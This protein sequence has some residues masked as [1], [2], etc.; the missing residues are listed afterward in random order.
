MVI[1]MV[2]MVFALM[3]IHAVNLEDKLSPENA[4]MI[5]MMLNVVII[6]LV[7]LMMEEREIVYLVVN[8]MGTKLVENVQEVMISFVVLVPQMLI[9]PIMDHALEEV[10]LALMLIILIVTLKLLLVNAQVQ[11]TLDVVLQEKDIYGTLTKMNTQMFFSK[12]PARVQ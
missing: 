3:L 8:V 7:Q 4:Q 1:A 12:Y 6:F 10:V 2:E 11:I 5:Q 9:I